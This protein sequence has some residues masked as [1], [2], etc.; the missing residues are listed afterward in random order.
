MAILFGGLSV[1]ALI[2]IFD[3][4]DDTDAPDG[5]T[6]EDSVNDGV[7]IEGSGGTVEI[8]DEEIIVRGDDTQEWRSWA[9]PTDEIW[10]RWSASAFT[11]K[12]YDGPGGYIANDVTLTE[13]NGNTSIMIA[14][15]KAAVVEGQ[16]GLTVGYYDLEER[17]DIGHLPGDA[18]IIDADGN[19]I[20][21]ASVDIVIC[22]YENAYRYLWT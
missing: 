10:S 9:E 22:T 7:A 15:T 11:Y 19:Q 4:D 1:A 12:N 14:G 21:R 16:T 20:E 8:V 2:T 17:E 18:I 3:G 13:E 5:S 6:D